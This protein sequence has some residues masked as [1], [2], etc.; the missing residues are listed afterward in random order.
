[1]S[2]MQQL[3]PAFGRATLMGTDAYVSSVPLQSLPW[4]LLVLLPYEEYL[5]VL[6][7]LTTIT[8]GSTILLL[9][10]VTP[11]AVYFARTIADPL[12]KF[13]TLTERVA[14]NDFSAKLDIRSRNEIGIL[15]CSFNKMLDQL[16]VHKKEILDAKEY[17]ESILENMSESLIVIS[18]KYRITS[19]NQAALKLFGYTEKEMLGQPPQML[20]FPTTHEGPISRDTSNAMR[21]FECVPPKHQEEISCY[22]KNGT[23]IPVLFSNTDMRNDSGEIQ[24]IICVFLD[25][26]ARKQA[27]A[28]QKKLE[29]Q[30]APGSKDGSSRYARWRNR[31]RHQLVAG[32]DDR[33]RLYAEPKI[34]RRQRRTWIRSRVTAR[35]A[36]G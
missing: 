12:I 19:A 17:T 9:A 25:L 18:P 2:G 16:A 29:E 24:G 6:R 15:A 8:V 28:Q 33:I 32:C 14:Q 1:M 36:A 21:L 26:R 30:F 35:G 27:E 31:A 13:T 7:S 11:L 20:H 3:K 5:P 34:F 10:L 4:S 23:H 22:A